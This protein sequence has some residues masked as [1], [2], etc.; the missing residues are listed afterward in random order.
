[1]K[2]TITLTLKK[3]TKGAL[4]YANPAAESDALHVIDTI[5]LRKAGVAHTG[6]LSQVRGAPQWPQSITLTL[7]A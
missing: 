5:Y 3:E 6:A 2:T 7:E 4:Q 1:M